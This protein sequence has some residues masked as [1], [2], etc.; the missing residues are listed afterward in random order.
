M[1]VLVIDADALVGNA[2]TLI[3]LHFFNLNIKY[4]FSAKGFGE[5][6]FY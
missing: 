3:F 6:H 5:T 2:V 1:H 4:L